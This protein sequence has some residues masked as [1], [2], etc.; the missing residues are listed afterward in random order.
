[1]LA[2]LPKGSVVKLPPDVPLAGDLL[3]WGVMIPV[4]VP[5]LLR[6]LCGNPSAVRLEVLDGMM[7]WNNGVFDGAGAK[8]TLAP[9]DTLSVGRLMQFLCGYLPFQ[10][11]FTQENCYCADEY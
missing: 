4:D 10:D 8:T 11:S 3:P 7:P 6:A 5:R 2:R 1:M 9:T